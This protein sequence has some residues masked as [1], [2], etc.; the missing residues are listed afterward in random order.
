MPDEPE[1]TPR[2]STSTT[3]KATAARAAPRQRRMS[4]REFARDTNLSSV[5]EEV[6]RARTDHRD[7][8]TRSAWQQKLTSAMKQEV[9]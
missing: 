5:R 3:K 4:L 8:F 2:S 6:L 7:R 1:K 9:E